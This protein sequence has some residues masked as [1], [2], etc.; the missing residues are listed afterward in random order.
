MT[1]NSEAGPKRSEKVGSFFYTILGIAVILGLV[2]VMF[3]YCR[4]QLTSTGLYRMEYEG[5]IVDKS[6][7]IGESQTG[8]YPVRKLH[9]RGKN[10]QE[11]QVIVN[12]NLYGRAQSGMWI[13]SSKTGA[14]LTREEP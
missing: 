1:T 6:V 2:A 4:Q 10:G 5:K 8:S 14:E 9:I 3:I 12:E 13:K 7:T 11:F